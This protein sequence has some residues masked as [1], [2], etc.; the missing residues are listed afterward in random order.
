L[1]C[2][3]DDTIILALAWRFTGKHTYASKAVDLLNH[4][5]IDPATRMNPHLSFAQVRMDGNGASGA[6]IIE[7]KDLYFYLDAVRLLLT[8]R[9]MEAGIRRAF[10]AWLS[11]YLDWLVSSTQGKSAR[12]ARNNLGIYYDLQVAAISAFLGNH[13]MLYESIIRAQNRMP[14]HFAT[15]GSQPLELT[16]TNT[17]H[18]CCF[19]LQGW[20]NMAKIASRYGVD[21][22][23]YRTQNG[24]GLRS[25][26]EWFFNCANK[27][28]S[29]A[30]GH[31]FDGERLYPLW[32]SASRQ[33][34]LPR[35]PRLNSQAY[36]VKPRFWPHDGIRP[37]WNLGEPGVVE[38][39][40]QPVLAL[41]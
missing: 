18:Y 20:I 2:L 19:N 30:Q 24:I 3:F 28:W 15:D 16:R 35:L 14:Q 33:L 17:Q 41:G 32:F 12:C 8:A 38:R 31:G 4:F 37:Y 22:W 1:Q 10:E 25:A 23:R 13:A 9:S 5:F 36:L 7:I 27:G 39:K 11:N 40:Q 34:E 26:A 6:G 29:F 21:L